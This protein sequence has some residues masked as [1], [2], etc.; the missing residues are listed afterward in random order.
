[1][2]L[3]FRSLALIGTTREI[4]FKSG[5]NV[6]YGPISTG[7]T[8]LMRLLGIALGGPFVGIN[9]EV[10]RSVTQ[11]GARIII[12]RD[13]YSI[14][15]PLVETVTARVQIAGSN[16]AERLPAMSPDAATQKTFGV[17]LLERL[18]LP[19]LR[20]PQAPSRPAESAFIPVSISDYLRYC[21]LRQDEI[22]V[23]VLG[24]SQPFRDVKRR[25]VFRIFY[26]GYDEEVARLQEELRAVQ[27][28]LSQNRA[29][30][31]AFERF[32]T[33]TALDNRAELVRGL[34]EARTAL[35]ALD[36]ERLQLSSQEGLPV[37]QALRAQIS[38]VDLRIAAGRLD[39]E[40]EGRSSVQ[41]GEL[42]N[43]LQ[44]HSG[45][46]TRAIVAG[47]RFF[48]FE[49]VVCPRCGSSVAPGRASSP[50]CYVCLHPEPPAPTRQDLIKEQDRVNAQ[51]AETDGLV[52]AHRESLV[53]I[54]QQLT[55]LAAERTALGSE[56]DRVAAQFI[57]DNAQRLEQLAARRSELQERIRRLEDYLALLRRFDQLSVRAVSL[58]QRR[59]EIEGA[60]E[61]AQQL[62]A[63]TASRIQILEDWFAHYVEALEIPRFGTGVRAAIDRS[64]AASDGGRADHH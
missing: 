4:N 52:H 38:S 35:I 30:H 33:G 32:L 58:Q 54:E 42:A 37:T 8:A 25:Y 10:D 5:L 45:R 57:S 19:V 21:R 61:R 6:I 46:L 44:G 13:D 15:R 1:M 3:Q 14:V 22:D 50:T 43:E 34:E 63:L 59:S 9:P 47:E 36:N 28:E 48:D 7:K 53:F 17:W 26:G 56:L 20:V 24:S 2:R 41:L 29:G 55:T 60:L 16:S 62:D 23:D 12:G 39:L 51:I 27:S 31:A 49:F 11:L 40:R 18:E 64:E